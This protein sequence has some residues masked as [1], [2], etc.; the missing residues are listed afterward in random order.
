MSPSDPDT[1]KPRPLARGANSRVDAEAQAQPDRPEG[2]HP[3]PFE[4]SWIVA[5]YED[6]Y[7]SPFGVLAHDIELD[8][9]AD[10]LEP[11]SP[12]SRILEIGCGTAHFGTALEEMGFEVT[13]ADPSHCMLTRAIHR[14]PVV[15]ADGQRLPFATGSFDAAFLVA[16]L[17]FVTDPV[18]LLAEARRVSRS[19]VV[20]LALAKHSALAWRRRLAGWLGNRIFASARFY[21]RTQLE[22]FAREAGAEPLSPRAGLV[23]PPFLSARF[24]AFEHRLALGCPP[25]AGLYAFAL[26]GG[27]LD[28]HQRIAAGESVS[29]AEDVRQGARVKPRVDRRLLASSMKDQTSDTTKA[30]MQTTSGEGR[31]RGLSTIMPPEEFDHVSEDERVPTRLKGIVACYLVIMLLTLIGATLYTWPDSGQAAGDALTA[32][33]RSGYERGLLLVAVLAGGVGATINALHTFTVFVGNRSLR[34]SWVPWFFARPMI[35]MGLALLVF[36]V[37]AGVVVSGDAS[38]L[39][40][41]GVAAVSAIL[42]LFSK[43]ILEHLVQTTGANLQPDEIEATL[44]S[45]QT[46][47]LR[48]RERFRQSAQAGRFD[49]EREEM[50]RPLTSPQPAD[51]RVESAGE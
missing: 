48:P 44:S 28:R 18:A 43:R 22:Q 11:L 42:G 15:Q 23:L 37:L 21:S 30:I 17:D 6:W 10:L 35:G 46:E 47:S 36:F 38:V 20:V 34:L 9:L 25:L 5:H 39:R 16:V 8:F 14:L 50:E 24:P 49:R 19:R 41:F 7:A 31:R 3:G 4:D 13:G 40:P 51:R 45:L 32:T 1:T 29:L 26:V 33:S 2:V 27:W 12:G